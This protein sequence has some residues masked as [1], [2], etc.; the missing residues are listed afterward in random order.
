LDTNIIIKLR[1]NTDNFEPTQDPRS[2]LADWLVEEVDYYYA[3]EINNGK[4][5]T[6]LINGAFL[7]QKLTEPQVKLE[8]RFL[9]ELLVYQP[10]LNLLI[11]VQKHF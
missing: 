2:L 1:D 4:Q 7:F 11:Y 5:K 10:L 8:T 9:L 3:P 6:K